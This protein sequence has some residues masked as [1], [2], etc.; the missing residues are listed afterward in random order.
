MTSA[1]VVLRLGKNSNTG[2]VRLQ[3][4]GMSKLTFRADEDLITRLEGHNASKS[5][6]I[7][8]AL[9]SYLDGGA[10]PDAD[11]GSRDG[12][13]DAVLDRRITACVDDRLAALDRDVNITIAFKDEPPGMRV[14]TDGVERVTST[15]DPRPSPRVDA[16]AQCGE[17][18]GT[19]HV[20]C[21]NC[22]EQQSH[23]VYCDCGVELRSD[24]SFCPAC[25]RRTPAADVLE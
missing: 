24:W 9:R 5:E 21:P 2:K 12:S 8:E 25:G 14:S 17:A 18:V 11:P 15:S 6:V 1:S 23:R 4:T 10:I 16:C 13:I 20:Y 7:R 19:D 3:T 22:G